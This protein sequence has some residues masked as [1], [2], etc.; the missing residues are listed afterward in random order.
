MIFIM[1]IEGTEYIMI[2]CYS[3]LANLGINL[4]AFP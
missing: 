1:S 3:L 2:Q 4:L